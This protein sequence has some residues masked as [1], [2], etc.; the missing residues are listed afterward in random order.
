MMELVIISQ[1]RITDWHEL[2]IKVISGNR[3]WE[4]IQEYEISS[5]RIDVIIKKINED[6]SVNDLLNDYLS[7]VNIIEYKS[8]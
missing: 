8:F 6:S 7:L 3:S 4:V 2:F 1:K 5:T